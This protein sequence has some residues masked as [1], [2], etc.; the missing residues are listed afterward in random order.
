LPDDDV[1][2]QANN[3]SFPQIDVG[4]AGE[5][6]VGDR[7]DQR[8]ENPRFRADRSR[9]AFSDETFQSN[10]MKIPIME[11]DGARWRFRINTLMLLVIIL[12]LV[13]TLAIDHR[14]RKQELQRLEASVP[15]VT[16]R[17]EHCDG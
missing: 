5:T 8:H 11:H 10:G 9:R 17:K 13:L 16:L 14:K 12:A 4:T 15:Q 2:S 7:W 3:A 1:E 6:D